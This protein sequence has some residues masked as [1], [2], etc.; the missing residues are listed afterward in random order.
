MGPK[1]SHTRAASDWVLAEDVGE[2]GAGDAEP[3]PELAAVAVAVVAVLV[4]D[5]GVLQHREALQAPR[6]RLSHDR[7]GAYVQINVLI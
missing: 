6:R 1:W 5:G 4:P 2:G 3:E 7:Q